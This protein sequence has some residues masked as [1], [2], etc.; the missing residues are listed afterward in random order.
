MTTTETKSIRVSAETYARLAQL[1]N[2][3]ESFDTV[4]RRLIDRQENNNGRKNSRNE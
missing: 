4:I 1:G 2:L 3:S